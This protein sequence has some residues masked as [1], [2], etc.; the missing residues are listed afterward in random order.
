MA[1]SWKEERTFWRDDD[2]SFDLS[3]HAQY[4]TQIGGHGERTSHWRLVG[5]R[6]FIGSDEPSG[7]LWYTRAQEEDERQRILGVGAGSLQALLDSV[8]GWSAEGAGRW[9]AGTERLRCSEHDEGL[10]FVDRFVAQANFVSAELE[11][12][13]Q[14]RR[15]QAK[16][17]LS[18]GSALEITYADEVSRD[19]DEI[20]EPPPAEIVP[21]VSDRSLSR[22]RKL[23]EQ[24]VSEGLVEVP[25][26]ETDQKQ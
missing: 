18:D 23:L 8:D 9:T 12:T 19:V 17:R 24:L 21:V 10:A 25:S 3:T 16:W 2:E 1:A 13:P 26:G 11:A 6:A 20:E 22:S 4:V 7:T 14:R 5:D 15:L